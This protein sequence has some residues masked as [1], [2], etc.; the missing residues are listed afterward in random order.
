MEGGV[1]IGLFLI[2]D[3]FVF[4][5]GREHHLLWRKSLT[6]VLVHHWRGYKPVEGLT[7]TGI[8]A[9]LYKTKKEKS[10]NLKHE[11]QQCSLSDVTDKMC[12]L[13]AV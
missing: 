6:L 4:T 2:K 10:N 8:C 9:E 1:E 3:A 11:K 13:R 5:Y 7:S 12:S